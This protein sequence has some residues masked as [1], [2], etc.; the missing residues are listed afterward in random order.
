MADL[1]DLLYRTKRRRE[2][3]EWDRKQEAVK[4]EAAIREEM[5]KQ[6][7]V[8]Q[9]R[10]AMPSEVA[11][12]QPDEASASE[13]S[14]LFFAWWPSSSFP[15]PGWP[16]VVQAFKCAHRILT[17]NGFLIVADPENVTGDG[18]SWVLECKPT[19]K[20]P[21]DV[22]PADLARQCLELKG[23][24]ADAVVQLDESDRTLHVA[25]SPPPQP[26]TSIEVQE[27]PRTQRR[28]K[29]LQKIYGADV[30]KLSRISSAAITKE[31]RDAHDGKDLSMDYVARETMRRAG[32]ALGVTP[33]PPPQPEAQNPERGESEPPGSMGQR[34]IGVPTK[35]LENAKDTIL[36]RATE[37][38]SGTLLKEVTEVLK[39]LF[40]ILYESPED[41]SQAPE[42]QEVDRLFCDA[43]VTY[44]SIATG[45]RRKIRGDLFGWVKE[46]IEA[47]ADAISI[48]HF[49]CDRNGYLASKGPLADH[50]NT[51][52]A[53]AHYGFMNFNA[54]LSV[55]RKNIARAESVALGNAAIRIA[56][57]TSPLQRA[58]HETLANRAG[59]RA[60]LLSVYSSAPLSEFEATVG[61][62]MVHARRACPTKYLPQTEILKIAALLD[63][64]N[65]DVRANL[66]R[67][68]A[69]AMAEYNQRHPTA[70]IKSW[71]TALGQPQF[72]RA[73]RKRF[74]RAEE[75]YKK[76]TPS[77]AT[78][79]GGTPRTTI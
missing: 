53:M 9:L 23:V 33:T 50:D 47:D 64:T 15:S 49:G 1:D 26:V 18:K 20:L 11:P 3:D 21:T 71:R 70:A 8:L 34:K 39:R 77:V 75:K 27:E 79:S 62:L 51:W 32:Q 45:N 56:G 41:I 63:D 43:C 46:K 22:D 17:T 69:R 5:R 16:D 65:F 19:A 38:V 76:A 12:A 13:A 25:L 30:A 74:S 54:V 14:E 61:K 44:V 4:R 29:L 60:S 52:R 73:V 66:E 2:E 24:K 28:T 10:Q 35:T 36:P 58:N 59:S 31:W 7:I 72:R 40:R 6:E 48:Q 67:G 55:F 57:R 68:A 37:A 42:W 78:P